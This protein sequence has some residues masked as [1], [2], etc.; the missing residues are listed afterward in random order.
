[1]KL[2]RS[3]LNK[4]AR[5]CETLT[6]CRATDTDVIDYFPALSRHCLEFRVELWYNWTTRSTIEVIRIIKIYCCIGSRNVV[7]L[8]CL[9]T[10]DR[11][12]CSKVR[13]ARAARLH[14]LVP[15]IKVLV[16]DVVVVAVVDV[17]A[18]YWPFSPPLRLS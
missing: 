1:M 11:T 2:F 9:F 12:N 17:K 15:P 16:C 7:I 13:A 10:K 4:Y 5:R 8:R 18:L 14:F 3:I 6:D